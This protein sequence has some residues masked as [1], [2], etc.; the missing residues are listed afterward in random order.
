[1]G[2][3][4]GMVPFRSGEDWGGAK[5]C[6]DLLERLDEDGVSAVPGEAETFPSTDLI[7]PPASRRMLPRSLP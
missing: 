7:P 4:G 5:F 3:G 6:L 1:M 2:V